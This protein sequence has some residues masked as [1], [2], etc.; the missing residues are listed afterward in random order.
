MSN[1]MKA[2]KKSHIE[3]S[4]ESSADVR[5]VLS[6]VANAIKLVSLE[7]ELKYAECLKSKE[8]IQK[9]IETLKNQ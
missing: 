7:S 5:S 2:D 3:N 6:G 1:G 9:K 4:Y 8:A